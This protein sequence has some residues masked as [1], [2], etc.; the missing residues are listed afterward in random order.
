M[1]Q[2]FTYFSAFYKALHPFL[3]KK[4]KQEHLA[5]IP[6]KNTLEFTVD[7]YAPFSH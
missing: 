6:R 7:F 3:Q 1:V 5:A 2:F 4:E